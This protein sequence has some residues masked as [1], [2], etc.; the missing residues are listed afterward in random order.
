MLTLEEYNNLWND[1]FEGINGLNREPMP[2]Y[3]EYLEAENMLED[4][5]DIFRGV[6]TRNERGNDGN[7]W[8]YE[9]PF[10]NGDIPKLKEKPCIKYIMIGEARPKLENKPGT[11]FYNVNHL[12][13]TSWLREPYKAF[14]G[15]WGGLPRTPQDKIKILLNLATRGYILI[16][17]FPFALNYGSRFNNGGRTLRQILANTG[18]GNFFFN[19]LIEMMPIHLFCEEN[20]PLLAFSGPAVSHHHIIH[21]LA[22]HIIALPFYLDSFLV[23]NYFIAPVAIPILLPGN[24]IPW[25]PLINPLNLDARY[26]RPINIFHSPFYKSACWDKSYQGP[27]EFFIRT[28]FNL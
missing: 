18:V 19:I 11:Y 1:H 13:N 25:N 12:G 23:P 10:F 8:Y 7:E 21:E 6:N 15:H 27:N 26:P 17:L 24:I 4:Y 22:N 5:L 28:A 16:D 3:N 9:H 2:P 14:F 20:K